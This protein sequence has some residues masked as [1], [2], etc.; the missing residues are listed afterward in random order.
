[1][2]VD[3]AAQEILR[4]VARSSQDDS[5][6]QIQLLAASI[7]DWDSLFTVARQHRVL[8]LLYLLFTKA[9][10]TLPSPAHERL[11]AAYERNVLQCMANVAELIEVLRAFDLQAIPAIPFKGVVLAASIYGDLT[12]RSAGDLDV[13][14]DYKHLVPTTEI[15]LGRGYILETPARTDG[16]PGIPDC[17]EYRFLRQATG[18]VLELRWRI[19]LVRPQLRSDLDM[20]WAWPRRT[21]Q[22]LSGAKVPNMDPESTLLMLC[23]HGSKH[24]WSRLVWI[25]DV[26]QLLAAFPNLDWQHVAEDA[27]VLGLWRALALGALL[28]HRVCGAT[29][30]QAVLNQFESDKTASDLA[31]HIDANILDAPGSTPKSRIP[32]NIKLLA[33]KDR[34]RFFLSWELFRPN[35]RDQAAARLPKPLYPLYFLVRPIRILLDKTP[36]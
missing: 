12:A 17:Y 9:G 18:T 24:V 15:L 3:S 10:V 11:R 8:S 1:M 23:I 5:A 6:E 36:R 28:A 19:E 35:E 2:P 7:L 22:I 25:M 26:G 32:Y 30:P 16:S 13:L 33:P 14:I 31:R 4:A 27:K 20:E 29:I 21:A 34:A